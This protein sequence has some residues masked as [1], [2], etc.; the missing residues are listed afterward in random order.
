MAELFKT[1]TGSLWR[2]A[3]AFILPTALT[4]LAFWVVI[5]PNIPDAPLVRTLGRLGRESAL[6][7]GLA[8]GFAVLAV[9]VLLSLNATPL[10]RLL[11]GYPIPQPFYEAG[12]AIQRARRQRLQHRFEHERNPARRGLLAE[13]LSLYPER[14]DDITPTAY[15]NAVASVEGYSG[16]RF[17]LDYYTFGYE[18]RT[19]APDPLRKELEDAEAV[20]NF[21]LA[22][23]YLSGLFGLVALAVGVSGRDPPLCVAGL[24]ALALARFFYIRAVHSTMSWRRIVRALVHLVRGKL[25]EGYGLAVPETLA[26]ERRLW[27]GLL[28]FV[29]FGDNPDPGM[30]DELQQDHE[31]GVFGAELERHRAKLP[32]PDE[33]RVALVPPLP[34]TAVVSLRR[35]AAPSSWQ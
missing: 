22:L 4:F 32:P 34:P 18:L 1:L 9:A 30:Q 33:V 23:I 25:L 6:A 17:R 15:G 14:L 2:F 11:E 27:L 31:P 7:G 24:V 13:L 19:L 12:C 10:S 21:F 20:V 3:Y 28:G 35:P 8:L 5:V 26:E 16:R 29:Y